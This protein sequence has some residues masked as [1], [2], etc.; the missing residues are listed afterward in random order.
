MGKI[1]LSEMNNPATIF[2]RGTSLASRSSTPVVGLTEPLGETVCKFQYKP[3]PRTGGVDS[4]RLIILNPRDEK[5]DDSIIRCE[6]SHVTFGEKPQYEAL[7]YTWGDPNDLKDIIVDG[8]QMKVRANLYSAL[9]HLRTQKPRVLW[10]DAICIDQSNRAEMASQVQLM[11]TIFSKAQRTLIWLGDVKEKEQQRMSKFAL[12]TIKAGLSIFQWRVP[13]VASPQVPVWHV[14]EGRYRKLAPFSSEFYLEVIGMLRTPWFKRAWVVQEVVVSSKAT[15]FWGS[16]QYDWEDVIRALKFMREANFP[17]AFIVTLENI[18]TI[19]QERKFYRKGDT[20][21]NGVLL[22]HQRCTATDPRDKIYSFCGLVEPTSENHIPVR[23]SYEDKDDIAVI[24]R[25]VALEIL[26]KD[27][28]LDLLSRPPLSAVSS[29]TNLPSWVPDWS[30]SA[31]STL[32]YAWGHGP[33]SLAGT[34]LA[35]ASSNLRFAASCNSKYSPKVSSTGE[36]LVVEGYQFDKVVEA[37]SIFQGVQMPYNVESF[38]QIVREWI[39]CF[40]TL[41]RARKVF[42]CWQQVANIHSKKTYVT[43]E[44]MR[45]AHLQTVSVAEVHDADRVKLELEL[46]EKGTRFPFGLPYSAFIF[47]WHFVASK[48]FLVFELQGRY[49]L[50]R[51]IVRTEAGYLGLASNTTEVGD[52]VMICKGSSVPLIMRRNQEDGSFRL[53]GDAYVHGI[54]RGEAFQTDKCHTMLVN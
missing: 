34:E 42:T 35:G 19:D 5:D 53:I 38:P 47:V 32:N 20:K 12:Y 28:S 54:M 7:S 25:E 46:W 4:I 15:I 33:L 2:S 24:Y 17:L 22:R 8:F 6:L 9:W 43:G 50:R 40:E 36:G 3:L 14:H 18:S 48:P 1:R 52:S 27:Q 21:L 30:T 37:G 11:R 44:T 10:A 23:I 41:L 26:E 31:T 13:L 51:K 45:E 49:L 29:T 16:S 39:H